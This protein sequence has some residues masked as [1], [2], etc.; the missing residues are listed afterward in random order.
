MNHFL[1]KKDT[2]NLCSSV[3]FVLFPIE[4]FFIDF[5]EEW[6]GLDLG[7]VGG[8]HTL[9][10]RLIFHTE[11]DKILVIQQNILHRYTIPIQ[12]VTSDW[13]WI[14]LICSESSQ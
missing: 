2:R 9:F 4:R 8:G 5:T 6:D 7:P 10:D 11:P 14:L 12:T 13:S 1:I 3:P